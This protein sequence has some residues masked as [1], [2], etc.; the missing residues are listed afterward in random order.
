MPGLLENLRLTADET[1]RLGRA[2]G[3]VRED[4][5][6]VS[7]IEPGAGGG[8]TG[9]DLGPA[10]AAA[11]INPVT[12]S[13]GPGAAVPLLGTGG[14]SG[15][16]NSIAGDAGGG[17]TRISMGGGGGGGNSIAPNSAANDFIRSQV[18]G[19]V[20]DGVRQANKPVVGVLEKV[21]TQLTELNRN[22]A[23]SDGGVGVRA[24]R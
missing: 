22:L 2:T 3:K 13:P 15:G 23:K 14:G 24:G 6:A 1:E 18:L 16:G 8:F 9:G 10:F 12:G 19:G 17:G 5:E 21:A 20:S 7:V 11:T 4:L